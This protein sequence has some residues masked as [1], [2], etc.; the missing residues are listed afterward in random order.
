MLVGRGVIVAWDQQ[1]LNATILTEVIQDAKHLL[2][3]EIDDIQV[4]GKS[5]EACMLLHCHDEG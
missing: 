4:L 2:L 3:P 5:V 1:H